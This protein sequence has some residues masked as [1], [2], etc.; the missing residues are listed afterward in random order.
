MV[1][2]R[3]G[4]N[5]IIVLGPI[6]R[7]HRYIGTCDNCQSRRWCSSLHILVFLVIFIVLYMMHKFDWNTLNL[8][9]IF[10]CSLFII[11]NRLLGKF[12]LKDWS[13]PFKEVYT[14]DTCRSQPNNTALNFWRSYGEWAS[15]NCLPGYAFCW[16]HG[17]ARQ[18]A[19][20]LPSGGL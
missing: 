13:S 11:K 14:W 1:L 3:Y 10:V 6:G 16:D 7:R 2:L 15:Q 4:S 9:K 19:S 5:I 8:H 17:Y 18:R 12:L 20:R